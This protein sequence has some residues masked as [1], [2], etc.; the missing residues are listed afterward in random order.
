MPGPKGNFRIAGA[1]GM[2]FLPPN[3]VQ[4]VHLYINTCLSIS[5]FFICSSLAASALLASA[6]IRRFS[7]TCS[8]FNS[9]RSAFLHRQTHK[10][11]D[12][13]HTAYTVTCQ[14]FSCCNQ[15]IYKPYSYHNSFNTFCSSSIGY[16]SSNHPMPL[17]LWMPLPLYVWTY[18]CYMMY[19]HCYY[20]KCKKLSSLKLRVRTTW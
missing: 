19:Y 13:S 16:Q 7:C 10:N 5:N 11:C 1:V 17:Y 9:R 15:L 14:S 12:V 4:T 18:W 6:C 20:Y 2:T 3:H 8:L